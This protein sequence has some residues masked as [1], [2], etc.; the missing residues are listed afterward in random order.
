MPAPVAP[1]EVAAPTMDAMPAPV[2]PVEVAAPTMEPMPAPIAPVEVAAPAVEPMP[3]P[4][5]PVDASAPAHAAASAAPAPAAPTPAPAEQSKPA[6][7][8]EMFGGLPVRSPQAALAD[9]DGD[10][11]M[12]LPGVEPAA[13]TTKAQATGAFAAFASGV[14]RAETDTPENQS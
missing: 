1:V 5:A 10:K 13:P 8:G 7:P 9:A 12:P 3:A 4:I 11:V 14:T 2:A 6:S